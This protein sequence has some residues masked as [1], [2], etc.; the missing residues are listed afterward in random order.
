VTE[1]GIA[2]LIISANFMGVILFIDLAVCVI[3]CKNGGTCLGA[4]VCRCPAGYVGSDCGTGTSI[5]TAF[6]S[7]SALPTL[8]DL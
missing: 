2:Y 3:A 1:D 7:L 4:N 8:R 6:Y 5:V